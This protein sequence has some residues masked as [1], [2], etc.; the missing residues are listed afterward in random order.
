MT[1]RDAWARGATERD[2]QLAA[3]LAAL[4]VAAHARRSAAGSIPLINDDARRD[5]AIATGRDVHDSA[6]RELH[7]SYHPST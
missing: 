1:L 6:G 3:A 2:E 4:L 5:V 7:E